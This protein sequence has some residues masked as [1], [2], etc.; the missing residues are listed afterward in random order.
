LV[1][2]LVEPTPKQKTS[3]GLFDAPSVIDASAKDL[4]QWVKP[5]A[6][7][8]KSGICMIIELRGEL[9][10][11]CWHRKGDYFASLT[12]LGM[13]LFML[14]IFSIRKILLDSSNIKTKDAESFQK[15]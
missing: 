3:E 7:E 10:H 15:E 1:N 2:P 9:T 4:S 11:I 14:N 8:A 6:T 12:S 13:L 5:T